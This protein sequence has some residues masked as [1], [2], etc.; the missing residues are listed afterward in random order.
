MTQKT[1]KT[2]EKL[3]LEFQKKELKVEI[4]SYSITSESGVGQSPPFTGVANRSV[5]LALEVWVDQNNTRL[6]MNLLGQRNNYKSP[7]DGSFKEISIVKNSKKVYDLSDCYL[8]ITLNVGFTLN[9]V[10]IYF[11]GVKFHS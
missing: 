4:E 2:P 1:S 11:Q 8:D 7:F 9:F 3:F 6:L 10:K 5:K